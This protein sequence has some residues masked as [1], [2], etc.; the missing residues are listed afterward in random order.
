MEPQP[1]PCDLNCNGCEKHCCLS[2]ANAENVTFNG[3][4]VT[5][6]CD[7]DY[8]RNVFNHDSPMVAGIPH[9]I[10]KPIPENPCP[11]WTLRINT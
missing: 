4:S 11:D 9:K 2:C 7:Y 1:E 8:R 3:A 6:W 5:F 10:E